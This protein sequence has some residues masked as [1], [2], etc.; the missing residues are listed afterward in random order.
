MPSGDHGCQGSLQ[1]GPDTH[2]LLQALWLNMLMTFR[3]HV[4]NFLSLWFS[5]VMAININLVQSSRQDN[6]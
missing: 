4:I 5:L 6:F 2:L 1:E 3:S